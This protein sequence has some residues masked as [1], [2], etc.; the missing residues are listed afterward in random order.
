MQAFISQHPKKERLS[1][2]E[3][4]PIRKRLEFLAYFSSPNDIFPCEWEKEEEKQ[5]ASGMK[6]CCRWI[7]VGTEKTEERGEAAG[8]ERESLARGCSK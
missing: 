4:E 2:A 5:S 7:V 6:M 1:R 3:Y 8:I